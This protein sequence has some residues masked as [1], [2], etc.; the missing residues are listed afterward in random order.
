[1]N[2][3]FIQLLERNENHAE[4]LEGSFEEV[5]GGQSPHLVTV[6]CS[7]S[8]VLQNHALG[9]DELGEV[10]TVSNIG[11]RVDHE[12]DGDEVVSGDMIYPVTHT[13]TDT[14]VVM[15]HTGCGAVTATYQNVQGELDYEAEPAGIQEAVDRLQPYIEEGVGELPEGLSEDEAVNHLVEYNVDKQ[16]E[17]LQESDDVP[18]GVD[19]VGMVYDLHNVYENGNHGHVYITNVNGENSVKNLR[20]NYSKVE[21][22]IDRLWEP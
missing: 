7:D 22:K 1:M 8:R 5:Q 11:N 20:E 9:N 17:F 21:Y 12:R 14:M 6:C 10:F 18:E 4:E 3:K 13:D 16:V 2:D 19:V 15:G